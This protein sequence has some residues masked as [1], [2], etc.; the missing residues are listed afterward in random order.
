MTWFGSLFRRRANAA[1]VVVADK[2][3]GAVHPE[4]IALIKRFEGFRTDAY[5]CPAGVWTIGYGTT[6]WPD[7]RA[8]MPGQAISEPD[9]AKLA[10]DQ[11]A[12]FARQ[13]D[14]LVKVPVNARERGALVSLAYNIGMGAFRDSTL[15]RLLNEGKK[16][17]AAAQFLRWNRGGGQILGG[18]V[19]RREAERALFLKS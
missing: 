3:G 17:D 4:A 1:P 2:P 6:R 8:V 12:D 15:L 7:G 14:A 11:I 13:V 16:A 10:A 18:L 5:L 9:A 19:A